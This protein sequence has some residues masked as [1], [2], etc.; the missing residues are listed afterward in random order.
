MQATGSSTECDPENSSYC[1]GEGTKIAQGVILSCKGLEV[2]IKSE[3]Q[4]I[5]VILKGKERE[6][7]SEDYQEAYLKIELNEEASERINLVVEYSKPQDA[8]ATVEE[9]IMERTSIYV[10]V[11]KKNFSGRID[12]RNISTDKIEISLTFPFK[13][14]VYL[15]GVKAGSLG[16]TLKKTSDAEG[17][18][19]G[20][21]G[22][23]V[24]KSENISELMVEESME[25]VGAQADKLSI[26][27]DHFF[28]SYFKIS[29]VKNETVSVAANIERIEIKGM[30]CRNKMELKSLY[31]IYSPDGGSKMSYPANIKEISIEDSSIKLL[32]VSLGVRVRNLRIASNRSHGNETVRVSKALLSSGFTWNGNDGVRWEGGFLN[33]LLKGA[34]FNELHVSFSVKEPSGEIHGSSE[35]IAQEE[36]LFMI[37]GVKISEILTIE[38]KSE[39]PSRTH[40]LRDIAHAY[41]VCI[42]NLESS[43][44]SKSARL[45]L[46]GVDMSRALITDLQLSGIELIDCL[47]DKC[48]MRS[49]LY[50]GRRSLSGKVYSFM[51][52]KVMSKGIFLPSTI[53][54]LVREG[55]LRSEEL[56]DE[57]PF[58]VVRR[59][60]RLA[61]ESTSPGELK[62]DLKD[63]RVDSIR[64]VNSK[65]REFMEM[66]ISQFEISGKMF[67]GEMKASRYMRKGFKHMGYKLFSLFY[68]M[69]S[70]YGESFVRPLIFL[71]II[72]AIPMIFSAVI[73]IL[74]DL[75]A[76]A[77]LQ[78]I[79]KYLAYISSIIMFFYGIEPYPENILLVFLKFL[80][81]IALGLE[82][83]ALK[84]AFERRFWR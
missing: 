61:E 44:Y 45:S 24:E 41:L 40:D 68:D 48:E 10:Y 51:M 74:Q 11:N 8:S 62:I 49:I 67:I 31:I 82:F 47:W 28:L 16:F 50:H 7:E 65:M 69:I 4:H 84:R 42:H 35:N 27:R 39:L 25:L 2:D 12:L 23:T 38:V 43:R 26:S 17:V 5:S 73:P 60:V 64:K 70:A 57:D 79:L 3:D 1:K 75:S 52:S 6:S 20:L 66:D 14:E 36:A 18:R 13:G 33:A 22:I 76:I 81:A 30:E 56:P 77:A 9:K 53:A 80:G 83:I 72:S 54:M 78:I 59:F 37:N 55:V 29:D 46:R 32:D 21:G 58:R 34:E 19:N 63:I 71:S 15:C